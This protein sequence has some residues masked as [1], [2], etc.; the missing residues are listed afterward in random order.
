M[1]LFYTWYFV[2]NAGL[3]FYLDTCDNF[4]IGLYKCEHFTEG[5]PSTW[6]E[7]Y[8]CEF[9]KIDF[10][11]NLVSLVIYWYDNASVI[12]RASSVMS[13]RLFLPLGQYFPNLKVYSTMQELLTICCYYIT[14]PLLQKERDFDE[15]NVKLP[16]EKYSLFS[17]L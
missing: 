3:C 6:H 8:A 11:I 7:Q 13:L 15:E 2:S 9:H 10:K 14:Q 1:Y 17:L 16:F 12:C 5:C 4:S